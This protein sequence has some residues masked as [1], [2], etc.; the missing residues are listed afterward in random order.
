[1]TSS[2]GAGLTGRELI[3]GHAAARDFLMLIDPD[4][5]FPLSAG[6][7]A[8]ACDRRTGIGADGLVRVARTKSLPGAE[9]FA[10][11]VPEAEWFMDHYNADGSVAEELGDAARLFA[12]VL[13]AESLA[14]IPEGAS[15]TIGT[16]AGARAVTRTGDLWTVDMGT[17]LLPARPEDDG[18]PGGSDW[19]G[20]DTSVLIP[21]IDGPRAGLSVTMPAMRCAHTAVALV[22]EAELDAAIL[23][24]PDGPGEPVRYE[25]APEPGS[26]L[27]LIVALGEETD[28]GSGEAVGVAR[29]RLLTSGMGEAPSCGEGCCAAAVALHEWD[30]P[31]A[32]QSYRMLVP[33]GEIGVHVGARPASD[34]VAVLLTGPAQITGRITVL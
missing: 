1:M 29:L 4:C 27:E 30:G 25:P 6:A 21:G 5:Q 20:W 34:D 28:P 32:P 26:G 33:G 12:Q 10:E 16:R 9:R 18:E 19:Q 8:A 13:L 2:T 24:R 15:V 14:E 3:K 17:A 31:G 11:A 7:I 22:D 23:V